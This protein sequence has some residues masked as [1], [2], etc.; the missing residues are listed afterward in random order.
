MGSS[1]NDNSGTISKSNLDNIKIDAIRKGT[2]KY[3]IKSY[4][5]FII[6]IALLLLV[7]VFLGG[8]GNDFFGLMMFLIMMILPVLMLFRNKLPSVIPD[9]LANSLFEIDFSEEQNLSSYSI[10]LRSQQYAKIFSIV[11]L[12]IGALVL[13]ADYRKKLGDKMVFYKIMGSLGC[14]IIAGIILSDVTGQDLSIGSQ[15]LEEAEMESQ[16]ED[17][18]KSRSQI[19]REDKAERLERRADRVRERI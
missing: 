19:R 10:S 6:V 3:K 18:N 2:Q 11:V 16:E 8:I 7:F 12:I 1:D 14:L 13:I 15:Q 9:F 17:W 5:Y 4:V